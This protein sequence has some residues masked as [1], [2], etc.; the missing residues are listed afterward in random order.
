VPRAPGGIFLSYRRQDQHVAG[1]LADGLIMRFGRERVF[2]DVE[3][4]EPGADFVAAIT[5]AVG[6]CAVLIAVIG[7]HWVAM[8]DRAGARKLDDPH[9]FVVLEI[10]S[11][12]DR[13]IRVI[14]VLV[15]GA[16]MPTEDDLPESLRE[17]TRRQAVQIE[18]ATFRLDLQRILGAT[19]TILQTTAMKARIAP[20]APQRRV[21]PAPP[22]STAMPE[23]R[24]RT[25]DISAH[26]S[27]PREI[28]PL[29]GPTTGMPRVGPRPWSAS[30][31]SSTPDPSGIRPT[32]VAG[33]IALWWVLYV[34]A[35]FAAGN[36][37]AVLRAPTS[38]AIAGGIILQVFLSVAV[39]A[40]ALL[41]RRELKAQ[42]R[43][44][45]MPGLG[46][47]GAGSAGRA[48]ARG[49]VRVVAL[50]CTGLC[51]LFALV[52]ACAPL[53]TSR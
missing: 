41:L 42:R 21:E 4:I 9:D 29:D 3:T 7:P 6:R 34:V 48:L 5:E 27:R 10:K 31:H 36:F 15:D 40:L 43:I 13:G 51:L 17:L 47:T 44:L 32:R 53:T 19:D 50:I 30:G 23:P 20:A 8:T 28:D 14:P 35:L 1:R 45:G 16:D 39:A 12:L 38:S 2:L 52:I 26:D 18:H 49:H 11:A 22:V 37:G 46:S 24:A 33:R 25:P